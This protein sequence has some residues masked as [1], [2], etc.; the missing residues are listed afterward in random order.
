MLIYNENEKP[1]ES[2]LEEP[3]TVDEFRRGLAFHMVLCRPF[4]LPVLTYR[5]DLVSYPFHPDRFGRIS[6]CSLTLS[7]RQDFCLREMEM[8]YGLPP[9]GVL[10]FL[11]GEGS[12][13]PSCTGEPSRGSTGKSTLQGSARPGGG[14]FNLWDSNSSLTMLT[15]SVEGVIFIPP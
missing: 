3:D 2:L 6:H 5:V 12:G 9:L 11:R 4:I 15:S 7:P 10:C 8:E 1:G 14:S 13:F